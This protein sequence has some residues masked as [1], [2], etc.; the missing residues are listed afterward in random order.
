[1]QDRIDNDFLILHKLDKVHAEVG[2]NREGAS[3]TPYMRMLFQRILNKYGEDEENET[4]QFL[5]QIPQEYC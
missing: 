2:W 1:M 4:D 5:V 3:D